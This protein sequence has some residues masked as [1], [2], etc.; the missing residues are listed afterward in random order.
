[1]LRLVS[2]IAKKNK[3]PAESATTTMLPSLLHFTFVM[4]VL[5]TLNAFISANF[6]SYKPTKRTIPSE[7]PTAST[8]PLFFLEKGSQSMQVAWLTVANFL[9]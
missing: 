3:E 5:W 6:L 2:S 9:W 7:K 8:L 4:F 1:M